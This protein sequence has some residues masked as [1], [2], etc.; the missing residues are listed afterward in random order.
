MTD[1]SCKY[2]KF[3]PKFEKKY[4]TASG[5]CTEREPGDSGELI[6]YFICSSDNHEKCSYFTD[7]NKIEKFFEKKN[8]LKEFL[9][10]T[11]Y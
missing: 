3:I 11:N 9:D 5:R 6:D 4:C 2:Y 8:R 10:N 7:E 1:E